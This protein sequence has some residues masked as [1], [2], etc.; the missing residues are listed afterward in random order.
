MSTCDCI[1]NVCCVVWTC[2]RINVPSR[3]KGAKL[4]EFC[5][6]NLQQLVLLGHR[7]VRVNSHHT[8]CHI[9]T[10]DNQVMWPPGL[11]WLSGS[12]FSHNKEEWFPAL[13]DIERPQCGRTMMMEMV[14]CW[15][16]QH[17][18]WLQLH[19]FPLGVWMW[20]ES[21]FDSFRTRHVSFDQYSTW[22]QPHKWDTPRC[23]GTPVW[24][25]L[26]ISYH[27]SQLISR[28]VKTF[29]KVINCCRV[30]IVTGADRTEQHQQSATNLTRFGTVMS[31]RASLLQ[32]GDRRQTAPP[33]AMWMK[34]GH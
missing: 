14:E 8:C 29:I 18:F 10:N 32:T 17:H 16:H 12:T 25:T 9:Y 27:T 24:H 19:E 21:Q 1:V 28:D 2:W 30:V 13:L 6:T 20:A 26:V 15:Q 11:L 5:S 7:D 31:A 3:D 22:R 23:A 4:S 33:T 34:N